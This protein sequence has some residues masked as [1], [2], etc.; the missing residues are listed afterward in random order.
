MLWQDVVYG[1][2]GALFPRG[3]AHL[4]VDIAKLP[5]CCPDCGEPV[6]LVWM[7]LRC[8]GCN[9]KRVPRRSL[10]GAIQPLES[11]CRYCGAR[12]VRQVRKERIEAFELPYAIAVTETERLDR[13][14]RQPVEAGDPFSAP[15][16]PFAAFH[17]MPSVRVTLGESRRPIWDAEILEQLN[18]DGEGVNPFS[19]DARSSCGESGRGPG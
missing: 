1:V 17:R 9:V 16:Q 11:R 7:L 2:I 13:P 18:R 5:G 14:Q 4:R 15:F 8:R 12:E 19:P 6:Q 3:C 10:K